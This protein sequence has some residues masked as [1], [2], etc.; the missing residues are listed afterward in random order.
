M[1]LNCVAVLLNDF[2]GE[3]KKD[4]GRLSRRMSHEMCNT[5]VGH[6]SGYFGA[7]RIISR[8]HADGYQV[9]V[10]HGNTGCTIDKAEN[11][12]TWQQDALAECLRRHGWTIPKRRRRSTPDR[13]ESGG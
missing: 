12:P 10:V 11:L 7:G 2:C 1:G 3:L 8:D 4:D 9:V 6:T 5:I 13:T